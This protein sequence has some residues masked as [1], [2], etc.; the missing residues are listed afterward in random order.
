[1]TMNLSIGTKYLLDGKQEV[2]VLK[3]FNKLGTKHVIET[4]NRSVV[5]VETS[6]LT[7]LA[8]IL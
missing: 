5:L 3:S 1:M 8:K 2:T 4:P 6:R 7:S